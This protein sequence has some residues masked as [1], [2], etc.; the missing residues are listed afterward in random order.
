LYGP[1]ELTIACLWYRWSDEISPG[2]CVNGIVPIGR[3]FD[4]LGAVLLDEQM[5]PVD[6]GS[7]GELCVSG[8]QTTPGYWR[9]PLKTA[10]RFVTLESEG[11]PSERF[12]RTGDRV[13][14]LASGNYAYLGRTDQ[15]VKV[16]GHRVELGDIEACL[17]GTEGVIDAVA[18]A[19]PIVDGSAEGIVAWVTGPVADPERVRAEASTRLPD[20]MVPKAIHAIETMPLNANGKIDRKALAAQLER[21]PAEASAS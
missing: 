4:G 18:V 12:Y 15:Q 21:S 3:P 2:E 6:A 14:R 10:E 5:R 8:P 9:D 7:D 16:M 13:R 17:R 1:T 19:W 20:Y 11:F